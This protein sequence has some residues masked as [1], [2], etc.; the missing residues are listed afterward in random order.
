MPT[1]GT[2]VENITGKNT[3]IMEKSTACYALVLVEAVVVE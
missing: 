1:Q 3:E 2:C